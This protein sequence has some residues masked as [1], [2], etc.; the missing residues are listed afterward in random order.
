MRVPARQQT[1]HRLVRRRSS[2]AVSAQRGATSKRRLTSHNARRLRRPI[3]TARRLLILTL[4]VTRRAVA[5]RA[6]LGQMWTIALTAKNRTSPKTCRI[7]KTLQHAQPLRMAN[8]SAHWIRLP[9][10]MEIRSM[11]ATQTRHPRRRSN[12]P[13]GFRPTIKMA[14]CSALLANL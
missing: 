13:L 10:S 4:A 6:R 1:I 7:P 3:A 14:P 9:R 2:A 8:A 5:A 12:L 11:E